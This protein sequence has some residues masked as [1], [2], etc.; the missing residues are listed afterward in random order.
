MKKFILKN[1][2]LT[3]AGDEHATILTIQTNME[4]LGIYMCMVTHTEHVKVFFCD[5]I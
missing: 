1:T 3:L 4:V 5:S 2:L